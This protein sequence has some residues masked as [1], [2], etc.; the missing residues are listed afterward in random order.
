M[1]RGFMI[2]DL[3]EKRCAT[4]DDLMDADSRFFL[5]HP[6][7]KRYIRP[8]FVGEFGTNN[9]SAEEVLVTKISVDKRVRSPLFAEENE[10]RSPIVAV[11]ND[12]QSPLGAAKKKR[13]RTPKGRG[14]VRDFRSR[15]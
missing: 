10:R 9:A 1:I 3:I 14:K 2:K 12:P 8:H 7:A 11:D 4:F 15:R 13:R 5:E 6:T